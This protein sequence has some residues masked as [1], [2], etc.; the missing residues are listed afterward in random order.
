M[1]LILFETLDIYLK[2][3]GKEF[4]NVWR[5]LLPTLGKPT[6]TLKPL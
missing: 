1:P 4:Q 5:Y 2:L 3:V 6:F